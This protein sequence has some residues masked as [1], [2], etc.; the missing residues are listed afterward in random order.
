MTHT[1][2]PSQL[3]FA[4]VYNGW[5]IYRSSSGYEAYK[6]KSFKTI[7][8]N[9]NGSEQWMKDDLQ[10]LVLPGETFEEAA[11]AIYAFSQKPKSRKRPDATIDMFEDVQGDHSGR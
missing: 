5:R 2:P 11:A 10:R 4:A 1:I 3:E 9:E 6:S 8:K 7:G